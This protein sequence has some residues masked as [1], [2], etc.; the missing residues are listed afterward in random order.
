MRFEVLDGGRVVVA[1]VRSGGN[2]G[3]VYIIFTTTRPPLR[4]SL[5][6]HHH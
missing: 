2:N 4:I 1:M 5:E 3:I 6:V